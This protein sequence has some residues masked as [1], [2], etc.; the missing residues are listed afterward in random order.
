MKITNI[1][2]QARNSDRVNVSIDGKYRFSLD[3]AQMVD[4]GVK[5]GQEI[6]EERLAEL[7]R[8]SEFGK[9]YARTLE[10]CLMR[11]RST[12]EVRDYLYKKTLTK[13]YRTKSRKLS[14]KQQTAQG[15]T[16]S[17][18][19]TKEVD[20]VSVTVTERVYDRLVQRGHIDDEQFARYW[21]ENRN[22]RKGSSLRKLHSELMTKGVASQIIDDALAETERSDDDE[23]AKII[24]RKRRSYADEQ[25]L[26]AYL[27]RQG[28][29]YD[30]I[31]QALRSDDA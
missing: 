9:L 20:G 23:L 14:P 19:E 15:R 30:D 5:Q 10:Y 24:A 12:R 6:D 11:P 16:M 13:R 7:E 1:N 27:A 26:I 28:F 22:Q 31:V 2:I 25:K 17:L 29:R 8:E 3:I 18:P 21:I 4:L